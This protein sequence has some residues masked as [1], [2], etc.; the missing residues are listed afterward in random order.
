MLTKTKTG[1]VFADSY[2]GLLPLDNDSAL[3]PVGDN[4]NEVAPKT[5]WEIY[6]DIDKTMSEI[7]AK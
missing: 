3:W 7:A 2:Y 5:S 1:Y 6:K 4:L